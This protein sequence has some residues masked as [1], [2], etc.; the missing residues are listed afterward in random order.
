MPTD[1]NS[2]PAEQSAPASAMQAAQNFIT[3]DRT[4]SHEL[5][6]VRI[7]GGDFSV[8]ASA[9]R[10]FQAIARSRRIFYRGGAVVEIV[11]DDVD[12]LIIQVL[13]AGSAVSRFEEFVRFVRPG[14]GNADP[15]LTTIN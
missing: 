7:P 2:G 1:S 12:G 8:T 15:T 5:P 13:D 6:S 9:E 4:A 14:R 3:Q 10:L 11:D